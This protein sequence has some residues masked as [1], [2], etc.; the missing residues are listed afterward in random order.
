MSVKS[1]LVLVGTRPEA[2]KMAP[3][4]LRL[5]KSGV[6]RPLVCSTGQ[7]KEMLDLAL[8]DFAIAPDVELAVMRKGQNLMGLAGR[9]LL[10]LESVMCKA[11]PA[12]LLVQG[13]TTSAMVGAMSGFYSHIPVGHVEAGLRSGDLYAPYPEEFNRRVAALAATWHF[14][15]TQGA[16]TNLLKEGVKQER[17]FITGNTVVD[18]LLH[19]R[20]AVRQAPPP[21]PNA[22]E[23][24]VRTQ[25]PYV[26]ITGHRRENFGQGLEAICAAIVILARAHPECFF[27]YPVHLNPHVRQVVGQRLSNLP[28]ILLTEPLAYRPFVRLLDNC[29]FIMSD[30]GGIQEEAPSFGKQVLVMRDVTERPEGVQTGFCHLVGTD[31]KTIVSAAST[32]MASPSVD[33]AAGSPF[34]DGFAADR[35]VLTLEK[36]L[37]SGS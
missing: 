20:S 17:M 36:Q 16:A 9:L 34:G 1:V 25:K 19:M 27:I 24:I 5:K 7:H 3:I 14:A 15:P 10:A 11:A 22:I 21:L 8:A 6:L 12:C 26:L 31:T 18:A 29:L 35:I 30:S 13:D 37:F 23:D 28:N 33:V 2:I 32:L 4:I